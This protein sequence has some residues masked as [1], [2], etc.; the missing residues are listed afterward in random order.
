MHTAPPLGIDTQS[1][2]LGR[3]HFFRAKK[4]EIQKII[5]R[6]KTLQVEIAAPCHCSEKCAIEQ[7][8]EAFQDNFYKIGTG[9]ILTI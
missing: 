6:F 7:F 9:T 4:A 1:I 5:D 8:K 2:V 3:F